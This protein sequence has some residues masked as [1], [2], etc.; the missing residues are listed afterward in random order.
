MAERRT[1]RTAVPITTR[2]RY[3]SSSGQLR[4][5]LGRCEC[6]AEV[7]RALSEMLT[8]N[9]LLDAEPVTESRLLTLLLVGSKGTR[10]RLACRVLGPFEVDDRL[11]KGDLFREHSCEGQV[12]PIDREADQP[13]SGAPPTD[14]GS[15]TGAGAPPPRPEH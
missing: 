1:G 12:A 15:G 5:Q 6:G 8:G 11:A 3:R 10:S 9:L 2:R 14:Q 4:V 7:I 13:P